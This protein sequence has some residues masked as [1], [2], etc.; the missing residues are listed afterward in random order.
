MSKVIDTGD[1][2]NL[3]KSRKNQ[4]LKPYESSNFSKDLDNQDEI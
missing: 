3:E 4:N 2:E 1:S